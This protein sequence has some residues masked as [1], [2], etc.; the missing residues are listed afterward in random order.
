MNDEKRGILRINTSLDRV[1]KEND[2]NQANLKFN[3]IKIPR[4]ASVQNSTDSVDSIDIEDM[5][6]PQCVAQYVKDIYKHLR[7]TEEKSAPKYGYLANQPDINEKMRSILIDWLVDVQVKF[8]LLP[9]TLFM[10]A[11]IIDRYCARVQIPRQKLQ[12]I[13]VTALFIASKYEEIYPPEMKDFVFVTDRAYTKQEVLETE[14][15]II[16]QLEFNLVHVSPLRFAER[17][18]RVV[19]LEPKF[20]TFTRY[21]LEL[22]LLDYKML[23]YTPSQ[24][25]CAATYL[26][27]KLCT[28]P[29]MNEV[30]LKHAGYKDT[31]IKPI[32]HEMISL[33]QTNEKSTLQAIRRKYASPKYHDVSR[34]RINLIEKRPS[35]SI[36]GPIPTN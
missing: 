11:N 19:K 25:A 1:Q 2:K 21:M 20:S 14:G 35:L 30:L 7:A 5:N 33:L 13:G 6:M 23:K 8:K 18:S 10:A 28:R 15:K 16:S 26:A 22:C 17:Y 27:N 4:E 31:Q 9:E 24:L 36:G 32:V 29:E 3:A 34:I 12:L